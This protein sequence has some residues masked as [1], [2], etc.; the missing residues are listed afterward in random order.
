MQ[1]KRDSSARIA[2]RNDKNLS[3][4]ASCEACPPVASTS[5]LKTRYNSLAL[6]DAVRQVRRPHELVSMGVTLR[7]FRGLDCGSCKSWRPANKFKH[8]DG[9]PYCGHPH[10]RVGGGPI[11]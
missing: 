5:R 7:I 8:G 1:E 11:D 2:P 9:D 10:L 3:F 6:R 4:S